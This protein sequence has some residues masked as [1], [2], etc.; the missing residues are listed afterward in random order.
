MNIIEP[1]ILKNVSAINNSLSE[2]LGIKRRTSR[3]RVKFESAILDLPSL[4][5]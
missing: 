5:Q 4:V 2:Q 3:Q 1:F